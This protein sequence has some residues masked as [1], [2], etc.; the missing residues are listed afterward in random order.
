MVDVN[1]VSGAVVVRQA[2]FD[3]VVGQR[4]AL[5]QAHAVV[6]AGQA[7]TAVLDVARDH[8]RGQRRAFLDMVSEE[9]RVQIHRRGID[10]VDQQVLQPRPLLQQAEQRAVAQQVGHFVPVAHRVQALHRQV[11]G[12]IAAF[13]Q[14]PG[15]RDQRGT[16]AFADLLGLLVEQLL[17]HFLPGKPQVALHRHQAQADAAARRKQQRA[18]VAVI[19]HRP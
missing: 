5:H 13:T 15:P 1:P 11:A 18:G 4:Q 17:R 2:R 3:L 8:F 19:L 10:V 7:A 16:Q 9:R 14:L 12:V 6:H